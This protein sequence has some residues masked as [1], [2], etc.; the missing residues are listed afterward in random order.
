MA[1]LGYVCI[2]IGRPGSGVGL[3][4][5]IGLLLLAG[6]RA[7]KHPDQAAIVGLIGSRALLLVPG[8]AVVYLSFEAG[9]FFPAPPALVAV[10]LGLI[11]A[12]R[13]ILGA[14]TLPGGRL[15]PMIIGA[16]AVYAAWVLLS[17]SWSHSPERALREADLALVYGL[18]FVLA[19]TAVTG[20]ADLRRV[21][22][23]LVLG[24]SFVCL[25]AFLSRAVPRLWPIA[26][27][28]DTQR[29]SYPLT[30]WN[31][32][33][34][35]AVL[36]IILCVGL[37]SDDRESR[38]S[39]ALCAVP[40]PLLAATLLLTFSR[41]AIAAG[42]VGLAVYLVLGRPLSLLSAVAAIAPPMAIAVIVTYRATSLAQ[43]LNRSTI[44]A[45][46]GHHVAVVVGLCALGAGLARAVLSGVDGPLVRFGGRH[47]VPVAA[48]RT[49]WGAAL[50][51]A[52][53]GALAVGLP[54]TVGTQY[55]RFIR[56]SPGHVQL[57]DRLTD[58]SNDGRI[59]V[60][61]VGMHEFDMAPVV[62]MGAGTFEL[63]WYAHRPKGQGQVT[64]A[65]SIYVENLDELGLVGFGLLV[66]VLLAM[67]VAIVR[68]MRQSHRP[69]YATVLAAV[70]IWMIHAGIDWD[71]EMP[72]VSLPIFAI[73]GAALGG[74]G[75]SPERRRRPLPAIAVL[76][77]AVAPALVAV[78]QTNVAASTAAFAA[79]DCAT[80]TSTA[81][82]AL[83]PLAFRQG[84]HEI[85]A[86]CAAARREHDRAVAEMA[87][88][89]RDDP[90]NWE[91]RYGMAVVLAAIGRD[92]RPALRAALA[93]DPREPVVVALADEIRADRRTHWPADAAAAPLPIAG[94]YGASISALRTTASR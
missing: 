11:L 32:L 44:Q 30:Y 48:A 3:L 6:L 77:V 34:L 76:L 37:T 5:S 13:L 43:T 50:V 42:I 28:L 73:T 81:K 45:S 1:I 90:N 66:V 88:A 71:W 65:H 12:A 9:G 27:S 35:L 52:V 40:V 21:M 91:P 36:G 84:P 62:G 68:R 20:P 67:L 10:I 59:G 60:W 93:L 51:L 83:E 61:R 33:G 74:G 54:S 53:A 85:L 70:L 16:L 47:P 79:G 46:E 15:T 2:G 39:K 58:A 31:A 14:A 38:L 55:H 49:A 75:H 17:G 64:E 82:T 7:R 78:S 94:V 86:Y 4:I 29:I 63:A 41:G 8:A 72:A 26:A 69:L 56:G 92:P 89:V 80:A 18:G 57:R 25:A 19:A 87:S 22:R 24:I 23:G